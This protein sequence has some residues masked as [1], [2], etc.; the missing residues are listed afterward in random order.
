MVDS[1]V[2][3][4]MQTVD[5]K[6]HRL[7][8]RLR[9][10]LSQLGAHP[11]ASIPTACGS[12]A[13]MTA[14]YRLFDNDKATFES[15]LAPH[16]TATRQRMAA[17]AVVILAQ[18]TTEVDVTR[19]QQQV[20]GAGPLDGGTRRGAFLHPLH[21]FTPEGTPLGTLQAVVW[22]RDDEAVSCAAQSQAPRHARRFEDKESY[23]WVQ[24]LRQAG[25]EA[26]ACPATQLVCVADLAGG[27]GP[28]N[29]SP[30][31]GCA[32]GMAAADEPADRPDRAGPARHSILLRPLDDR[33]LLP[34]F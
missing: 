4:E 9:E 17:Q 2:A 22:T 1:S 27:A 7:D 16:R 30:Q 20:T 12:F 13:E 28:R 11:T 10:V 18:D 14:A 3:A 23:R 32:G 8:E 21:A 34:G 5:L 33:G 25:Q 15:I 19:P 31:G 26:H 6:D 29:R 24:T